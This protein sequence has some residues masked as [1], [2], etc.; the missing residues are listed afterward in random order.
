MDCLADPAMS[1]ALMNEFGAELLAFLARWKERGVDT[2]F[3][4]ASFPFVEDKPVPDEEGR[5]WSTR[6]RGPQAQWT[7]VFTDL[8]RETEFD[9]AL[10]DDGKSIRQIY[11][12]SMLLLPEGTPVQ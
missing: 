3:R 8:N 6:H 4:S 5:L 12:E 9:S 2:R 7:L 1:P 11:S 10:Y